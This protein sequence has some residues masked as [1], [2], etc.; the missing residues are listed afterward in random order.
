MFGKSLFRL[1][2]YALAGA[3]AIFL[4]GQLLSSVTWVVVAWRLG[5]STPLIAVW[6]GTLLLL[7]IKR[8]Q[9]KDPLSMILNIISWA[10]I[11]YTSVVML[12]VALPMGLI[13]AFISMG[14]TIVFCNSIM[15][16]SGI[17]ERITTLLEPAEALGQSIPILRSS[18]LSTGA[19]WSSI[20]KLKMKALVIP[21]SFRGHVINL[22]RERPLL[23][24]SFTRYEDCDILIVRT[25]GEEKVLRQ[26]Q[27]ALAEKAVQNIRPLSS[28]MTNAILGLPLLEQQ[29]GIDLADYMVAIEETTVNRILEMWPNRIT[30]FPNRMGLRVVVRYESAPGFDLEELPHGR[31]ARILLGRDTTLVKMGGTEIAGESTT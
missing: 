22:L 3:I 10:C 2:A 26:V 17:S 4:G 13:A 27:L 28:F 19:S 6:A 18:S 31:E 29:A 23:P 25:C 15:D 16:P 9:N 7:I 1:I 5:N 21:S 11:L 8:T 20:D 30:V 12:F 24:V 14:V